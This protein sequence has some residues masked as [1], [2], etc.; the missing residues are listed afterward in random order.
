MLP[1][2]TRVI[3]IIY[4]A[5]SLGWICTTYAEPAQPPTTENADPAQPPTTAGDEVNDLDHDVSV[6]DVL[7]R[8]RRSL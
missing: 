7:Y 8:W 6:R 3:C 2:G 4:M 1:R 5:R